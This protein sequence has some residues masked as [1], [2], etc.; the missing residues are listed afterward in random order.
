MPIRDYAGYK[1]VIANSVYIDPMALVIGQVTIGEQASL[2]PMVVVRGDVNSISIGARTNVQ[3]NAVLHVTH[4]SQY[5]PGGKALILGESITVGHQASLH[6]CTIE[7]H[8]LIGIGA[9]VLDG[10]ILPPYTLLAA[11][12]LVPPGKV[13]EGGYLWL[14]NP[15]RK[16]RALKET[17]MEFF[18]YSANHYIKLAQQHKETLST[19]EV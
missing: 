6:A 18:E 1:P 11:G 3:D 13:L 12:S 17:E 9:I 19:F 10:A 16:G 5:K 14:G 7:H 2:W 4:D 15:V 8:C